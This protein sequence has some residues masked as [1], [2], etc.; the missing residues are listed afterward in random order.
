MHWT[1]SAWWSPLVSAV[2]LICSGSLLLATLH[3]APADAAETHTGPVEAQFRGC[4]SAG[5]CRFR[6]DSLSGASA[7][8]HRIYPDGVTRR[9]DETYSKAVRDRLNAL[10]VNM[11]HQYKRIE[12]RE[13]RSVGDGFFAAIIIVDGNDVAADPILLELQGKTA[14]NPQ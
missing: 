13:L 1:A 14:G 8:L 4:N 7:S 12:L 6:I 3:A 9:S 10:L 5:W 2:S 11:I